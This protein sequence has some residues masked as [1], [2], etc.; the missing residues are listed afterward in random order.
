MNADNAI[1]ALHPTA[2]ASAAEREVFPSLLKVFGAFKQKPGLN[3]PD[4]R[5]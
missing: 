4:P 5:N 1:S 3:K 2:K